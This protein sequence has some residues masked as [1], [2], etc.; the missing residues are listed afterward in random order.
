MTDQQGKPSLA[1]TFMVRWENQKKTVS[2]SVLAREVDPAVVTT[3]PKIIGYPRSSWRYTFTDGSAIL[4]YGRGSSHK[5]R[6]ENSPYGD[7]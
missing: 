2:V 6:K 5:L 1:D 4:A 3:K 7:E